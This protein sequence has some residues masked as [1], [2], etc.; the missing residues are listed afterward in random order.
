MKNA[1]PKLPVDRRHF[2]DYVPG[3]MAVFGPI[4]M[5]EADIVEFALR[6]DPQPMHI[7]PTAAAAGPFGG[8]IA[9]GWHTVGVVMRALVENHLGTDAALVSPG[10]DEL[11]WTKPV[12]PGDA[13]RVRV[14]VVDAK[15][16]RSKPD[17]G[18]V[19]TS[20]VAINQRDE[21][22]M[23]MTAMNLFRC[24]SFGPDPDAESR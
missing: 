3:T 9:S 17:R 15:R 8:L 6:Y 18:M 19:R 5:T 20:I 7:D 4:S 14:T 23:S 2:E 21:I 16:S 24:R 22:V 13:L 12:R 11:R 1:D 10:I